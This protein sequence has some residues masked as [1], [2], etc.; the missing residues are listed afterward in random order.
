[1]IPTLLTLALATALAEEPAPP[2]KTAFTLNTATV[3]QLAALDQV[4]ED[5]AQAIVALRGERGRLHSV[6]SLRVLPGMDAATLSDLRKH[7]EVEIDLPVGSGK[8]YNS[9]EEVLRE[10]DGEPSVQQVQGWAASYAKLEPELVDRW[11][12]ASHTFAFLP[13]LQ[14]EYRIRSDWDRD[15]D[16]LDG[17]GAPVQPGG[18]DSAVPVLQD[19]GLGQDQWITGRARW[20]LNELIMSSE[21][22]RVINES[23]DIVK[24]R[25][26]VLSEI[27][28]LYFERRR[29]QVDM[30]LDPADDVNGQ[31][32]DQIRLMEL[33]AS[34]DAY[35]GGRFSE[36]L[37]R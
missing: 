37:A 13:V 24:L 27:T 25:D 11:M 33:T 29:V 2:E 15:F 9:A 16:Y 21:S 3:E 8:T 34:I 4:D 20:D 32:K 36:A 7:T 5:E 28:Q 19:G 30:L 1:M 17:S 14:V 35:T 6:E 22:I 18:N 31:V 12:R 26:K 10:F 23:Q